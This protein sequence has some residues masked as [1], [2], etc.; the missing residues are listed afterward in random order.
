MAATAFP[1]FLE[2]P[3][4]LQTQ[5][6][7]EAIKETIEDPET[8]TNTFRAFSV[9]ASITRTLCSPATREARLPMVISM[10]GYL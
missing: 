6:W 4:E 5:V 8:E 3:R 2:L 7:E 1:R 10:L 9:L